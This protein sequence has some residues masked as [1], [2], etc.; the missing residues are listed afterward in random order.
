M[1]KSE[2]FHLVCPVV[3]VFVQVAEC[4]SACRYPRRFSRNGGCG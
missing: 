1:D 3:S 2:K 4:V